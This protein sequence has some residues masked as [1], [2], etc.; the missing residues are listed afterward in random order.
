M[1]RRRNPNVLNTKSLL[2]AGVVGLGVYGLAQSQIATG[3]VEG[4]AIK[5]FLAEHPGTAALAAVAATLMY[6]I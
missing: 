2:V 4:D 3:S 6:R 5:Q 1:R